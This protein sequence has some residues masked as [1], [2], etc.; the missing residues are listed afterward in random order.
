MS[1]IVLVAAMEREITPLVRGWQRS[2]LPFTQRNFPVFESGNLVVVLSGIGKKNAEQAARAAAEKYHPTQLISVGLAGALIR[3]LK[4]ASVVAPNVVVDAEN[5]TEY[6]TATAA[7]A[8]GGG[9]LITTDL[10][11]GA[12]AKQE[13]VERLHGLVVDMEAAAVAKVAQAEHIAFRCVKSISDEAEFAMPPLAKFMDAGGNF[14]EV[15]FALWAA[16]HPWN[17]PAVLALGKNSRR[18]TKSLCRW[19]QKDLAERQPHPGVVTLSR[20]EL[21]EARVK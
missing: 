20:A 2:T 11:A 13:L 3:S 15:R 16:L 6:R 1:R 7:G 8:I 21:S 4:V 17:W 18:A 5:G 10:V 9:I 14:H 12:Q 19:L